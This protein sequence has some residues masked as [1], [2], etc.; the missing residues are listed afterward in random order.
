METTPAQRALDELREKLLRGRPPDGIDLMAVEWQIREAVE[1]VGL[2]L[3][4]EVLRRADTELP[5]VSINGVSQGRG[6]GTC[7]STFGAVELER[8]PTDRSTD[9]ASSRPRRGALLS[10]PRDRDGDGDRD[11]A[12]RGSRGP[13]GDGGVARV[14]VSTLHRIPQMVM[15]ARS[16]TA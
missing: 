7:Y 10:A 9:G 1:A 4:A 16:A 2:E 12:P 14:S 11:A 3:F 5:E 6:R 13:V 8:T 15:A